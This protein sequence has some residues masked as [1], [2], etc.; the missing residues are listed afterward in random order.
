[1]ATYIQTSATVDLHRIKLDEKVL[2][3]WNISRDIIK[4]YCISTEH[5]VGGN[6]LVEKAA[7][8]VECIYSFDS[9][10]AA[11]SSPLA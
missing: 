6:N 7:C 9:I 1:M 8:C 11:T 3:Q 5:T 10:S 4:H 2:T